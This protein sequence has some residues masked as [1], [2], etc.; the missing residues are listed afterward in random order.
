LRRRNS[1]RT[2]KFQVNQIDSEDQPNTKLKKYQ[3]NNLHWF[4]SN[5]FAQRLFVLKREP[6]CIKCG[7]VSFVAISG[8]KNFGAVVELAHLLKPLLLFTY[9]Q[10][11]GSINFSNITFSWLA[12]LI[13][14]VIFCLPSCLD[15]CEAP[16]CI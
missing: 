14:F 2:G 6:V 7:E 5:L 10:P 4:F 8:D 1:H 15:G 3:S 9:L 12:I 11:E 16:L 13:S